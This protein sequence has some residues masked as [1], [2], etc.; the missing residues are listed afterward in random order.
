MTDKQYRENLQDRILAIPAVYCPEP[1]SDFIKRGADMT[2]IGW[3]E[4][5]IK[6]SGITVS[7][8]RDL[9]VILENRVPKS[10]LTL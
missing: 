1:F 6:D 7:R 2:A 5:M 4:T 10:A 9:C 8:L 3:S